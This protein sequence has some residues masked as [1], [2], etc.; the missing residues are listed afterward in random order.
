MSKK[1]LVKAAV[2]GALSAGLVLSAGATKAAS[3][4]DMEKCYGVAKAGM[5]D[6]GGKGTGHSC[7][8]QSK[9]DGDPNDW[10][11]LKK[12]SCEK[13]IGGSLTSGYKKK[14]R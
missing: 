12:G 11:Y 14:G 3:P 2:V 9:T 4:N 8:G 1:N 7:Q 5:N 13:I 6:C 10:L